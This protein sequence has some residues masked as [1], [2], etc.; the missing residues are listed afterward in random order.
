MELSTPAILFPAITLLLL[1]Y[2][3]RFLTLAS[4][5]RRLHNEYRQEGHERLLEQIKT[6]RRRLSLTRNMQAFGVASLF[7]C[8]TAMFLIF[9]GWETAARAVFN[10]SLLAAM[11]SLGFSLWEIQLS[12]RALDVELSDIRTGM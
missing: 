2:T 8:V 4:L 7:L 9:E 10:V 5:I 11:I 3:N 12:A 1:A 6:L